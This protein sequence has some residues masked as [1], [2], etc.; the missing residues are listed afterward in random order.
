MEALREQLDWAAPAMCHVEGQPS[1]AAFV[2]E[3]LLPAWGGSCA[4]TVLPRQVERMT[5]SLREARMGR[6][7]KGN[8]TS[9]ILVTASPLPLLSSSSGV[10][11]AARSGADRRVVRRGGP[12]GH[13]RDGVRHEVVSGHVWG[14][15]SKGPGCGH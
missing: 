7:S 9:P 15:L 6:R 3:R 5:V 8:A 14:G 11:G 4:G 10:V 2:T 1:M 12:R 13:Q